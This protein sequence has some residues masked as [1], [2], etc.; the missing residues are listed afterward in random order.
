VVTPGTLDR[1]LVA[2][3]GTDVAPLA[4][5]VSRLPGSG[6][7]ELVRSASGP[8]AHL[9]CRSLGYELSIRENVPDSWLTAIL[10]GLTRQSSMLAL[11]E[12]TDE[13]L[14]S[15]TFVRMHGARLHAA[16]LRGQAAAMGTRPFVAA[17]FTE[18][19][20]RL[21]IAG[22]GGTLPTLALLTPDDVAALDAN[23][24]E[25]LPR[26]LGA[27]L[28]VWGTDRSTGMALRQT[29]AALRDLP[30]V[31]TEATVEYGLDLLR[32][33]A[34]GAPGEATAMLITARQQFANAEAAEEGRHD[35]ALYGAG[36]DAV[37]AFFRSSTADL[38]LAKAQIGAQLQHRP[39]WLRH[40]HVPLWRRPREEAMYA[41]ARL[42]MIL[43]RA[44]AATTE[45]VWL[46]AWRAL[47]AVLD[48]YVLDRAVVPVL[49]MVGPDGFARLIRPVVETSLV[50]RQL[51]LAQL[52]RAADE[53]E[54]ATEPPA[55][56]DQLRRLRD[57]VNQLV[58]LDRH[59]AGP[60]EPDGSLRERLAGSAPTLIAELGIDA[61]AHVAG[62]L[63]DTGLQ[64]VEGLAYNATV[65]HASTRDPVIARLLERLTTELH[66]CPDYAGAVRHGFDAVVEEA[67][68]FLAARHDLQHSAGVEYLKPTT[69]PPGE[70]RLQDDFADWMRRGKLAGHVDVE[71]P[72]VATGRADVKLG[73]GAIRFY[74]EVKRELQ[75]ASRAALGRSYLP[76][77]ADYSGTSATLGIML[78]LDLT[79]HPTG[80]RHLS[81]CAWVARHRPVNSDV[82]RYVVVG[83]VVGNRS[84]P[85]S[86]SRKRGGTRR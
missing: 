33:L 38:R 15:S 5:L 20:L 41:W 85:S 16:F 70:V 12:A 67:V 18:G 84:T 30:Y 28:D 46:D 25:R 66:S 27:A 73:F 51:L 10:A 29:L 56:I 83:V 9:V 50:R 36:I 81:E 2:S 68:T 53:A 42:A 62:Q 54:L 61:A 19:A 17:A 79:S 43:D 80:V 71:V 7:D 59:P 22:V 8:L 37:M 39:A 49:G 72:N 63:D 45:N 65:R 21:V 6:A 58:A 47:D 23:Y 64:L 24:A 34:G 75:D 32:Q 26:L 77:T 55:R 1:M 76:Q 4:E 31:A 57:R 3:A 14:A 44:H 35:A 52:Q 11:T 13:L 69:P 78:V 86:Y 40:T 60:A 74:V 48:A 82:D